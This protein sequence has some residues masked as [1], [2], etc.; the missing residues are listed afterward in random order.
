M[1]SKKI[2]YDSSAGKFC[3]FISADIASLLSGS[4]FG[5]YSST[6]YIA[7][8][9]VAQFFDKKQVIIGRPNISIM[10]EILSFYSS[11]NGSE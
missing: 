11:D 10:V 1:K 2:L 5:S 7:A 4:R 8:F 9:L 6:F 3:L